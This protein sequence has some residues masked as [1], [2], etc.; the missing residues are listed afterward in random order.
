MIKKMTEDEKEQDRTLDS[1]IL[2]IEKF[3]GNLEE[4]QAL[5][6]KEYELMDFPGSDKFVYLDRRD[7][8]NRRTWR[9]RALLTTLL[10][11]GWTAVIRW[12]PNQTS[13]GANY[14]NSYEIGG[15]GIPVREVQT[16]QRV[17]L[18]EPDKQ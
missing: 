12:V 9:D 13:S 11:Q 15:Y 4:Y 2:R 6:K 10:E 1:K 14:G 8:T 17:T 3:P 5:K 16:V 7:H 18:V